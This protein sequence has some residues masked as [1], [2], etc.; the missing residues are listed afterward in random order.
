VVELVGQNWT[1]AGI[2]TTVKEVTPDEYRSAQSSN[3]LDVTI[4]R[5][6]QPLAIVLGNN[7]L[8]VPPF[9]DYFGIRTGMLW[10]EWVD[11]KGKGGVEPPKY[12]KQLIADINAFQSAPVGSAE[13]D[14]LGAR[15][16]ENMVG[17]LLFIGVVQAPAPIYHRNALKNFRSFTTHS[18][19]YYRTYPY[20][21]VQWFLD[22]E[23]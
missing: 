11:S 23:S 15:M 17:N 8:W 1:E 10:A 22:D 21:G 2:K 14:A 18:Y 9:S 20:R 7:E 19:E 16:V 3:Q 4:W 6:S 12:V 13:S 5:K